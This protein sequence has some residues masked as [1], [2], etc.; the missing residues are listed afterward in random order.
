MRRRRFSWYSTVLC[1]LALGC[2]GGGGSHGGQPGGTHNEKAP[3]PPGHFTATPAGSDGAEL[4]WD[5]APRAKTYNL[6]ADSKPDVGRDPLKRLTNI[7]GLSATISGVQPGTTLYF[8]VTGLND[9]GESEPSNE[10]S[11]TIGGGGGGDGKDPLFKH[12]WHLVNTGQEGGTPGEDV[13]VKSV[14]QQGLDGTGVRVAVV[15]DGLEIAHEDLAAN[16]APGLSYD[17]VTGGTDPTAGQHGTCCGGA[18]GAVR[19]NG[20]GGIGVAP[21]VNLVCYDVLQALT[22]ENEVDAM[23]RNAAD[24]W[25]ST[26]SWGSADG[27][28]IPQPSESTFQDAVMSGVQ[29]GRN[30]LGTVYLWAAGNGALSEKGLTDNSNLDGRANYWAVMA[31]AA[32][33]DDGIQAYYSES[34]ANL[35]LASPSMGREKHAITTVDRSG[36]DGYND[37]H[38]ESNYQDPNYTN[39]FNGTSAATPI[40][41]GVVALVLQANPN[42]T[43]RDV[44]LVLA[45]TARLNDPND[46]DWTVNGAGYHI[47]HRYG[48]GVVDAEAAVARAQSWQN[49][50]QYQI[51]TLPIVY[52]NL[53]IP[54][55]DPTGVTSTITVDQSGI[56]QLEYVR[57]LFSAADHP[58][59]ADLEIELTSPMG[60]KSLLAVHHAAPQG[61]QPYDNFIFGDA[62]LLG[63]HADGTWTLTV[64]DLEQGDVGT[65]QAWAIQFH[66]R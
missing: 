41:A 28:G 30:G 43:W 33:G 26:N 14:W 8:T 5:A 17:Y 1:A 24:V 48:F 37:G 32:V 50:G 31:V 36:A 54:D 3:D 18:L 60:T 64:R 7:D 20:K 58:W 51:L 42:L 65:L 45:E 2:G 52:P 22:S 34:G 49:V 47:N 66:G 21:G 9:Q 16:V 62:R 55:N 63:E 4:A 38:N 57:V 19:G 27:L 15:D 56:N 44:R 11:I 39:G 12:Q 46:A 29:T 6:Y 35:W 10:V 23:T 53:P 13:R 40:A 25:I 61:A 59:S